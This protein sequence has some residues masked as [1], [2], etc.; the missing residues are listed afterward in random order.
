MESP[1]ANTLRS[2]AF[3]DVIPLS[4]PITLTDGTTTSSI[5]VKKGQTIFISIN[6]VNQDPKMFGQDADEFKPERWINNT[7]GEKSSAT[8]GVYSSILTFLS[9]PRACIGYRFALLELKAALVTI[10]DE[11]QFEL[12][13]P[14]IKL[15]RRSALVTRP[16]IIGEE[17]QGPRMPLR[18]SIA[19]RG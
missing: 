7:F 13:E 5:S 18:M 16:Y 8:V 2:A 11:F 14:D 12:R 1:V 3:D 17:D 9:G 10:V 19:P 15:E 6:A 4:E